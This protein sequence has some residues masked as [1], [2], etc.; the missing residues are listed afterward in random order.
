[1][2]RI[3]SELH[4]YVCL[5]ESSTRTSDLLGSPQVAPLSFTFSTKKNF[6]NVSFDYSITCFFFNSIKIKITQYSK[7]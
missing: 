4:N 3:P 5:G 2:Y 6:Q 7:V 1:M